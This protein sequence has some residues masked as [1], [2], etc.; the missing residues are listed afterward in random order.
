MKLASRVPSFLLMVLLSLHP[1]PTLKDMQIMSADLYINTHCAFCLQ[2]WSPD[3]L[4]RALL[5]I[6]ITKVHVHDVG[7]YTYLKLG[8]LRKKLGVPRSWNAE[9]AASFGDRFLFL[10][11]V[12]IGIITDFL[13]NHT[14]EYETIVV[15]RNNPYD[16]YMILDDKGRVKVGEMEC[17]IESFVEGS[18]SDFQPLN[19]D[20]LL[21][22]TSGILDGINPCA[23]AVLLFFIALLFMRGTD[24]TSKETKKRILYMGFSYI[25]AVFIVYTMIGLTIIQTIRATPFPNF[26]AKTGA[27]IMILIGVV[28]IKDYFRPDRWISFRISQSRWE[29]IRRWMHRYT[30]PAAF[31]LGLMVGFFEFPCTGGIYVAILGLLAVKT[32]FIQGFAYLIAYNVAFVLPLIAVLTIA[33]K[34][35]IRDFS[36][37][38]WQRHEQKTMKLASGLVM[39]A[40]GIL[41]VIVGFA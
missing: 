20:P 30:L 17:S 32:T 18:T 25:A 4:T 31:T 11:Y 39:I 5:E 37:V 23:F 14:Q 40:L 12:S 15:F 9:V 3:E 1:F 8:E 27:M 10:G 33:S 29:T 35:E 41:L 2:P 24:A 7:E 36:L 21:V 16:P 26:L 22:V 6:G 19:L 34:K 13:V 28:N 38:R